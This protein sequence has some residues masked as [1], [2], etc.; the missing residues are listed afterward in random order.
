MRQISTAKFTFDCPDCG[1]N[2][3]FQ[4]AYQEEKLD[5]KGSER[6]AIVLSIL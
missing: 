4:E 1:K 5:N 6:V 2:V 3:N